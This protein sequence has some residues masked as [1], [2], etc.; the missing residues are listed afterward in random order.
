VCFVLA[1]LF[2]CVH[3]VS[4]EVVVSTEVDMANGL[5]K[6]DLDSLLVCMAL[7]AYV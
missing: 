6:N 7:Y 1:C 5:L 4:S 3:I 2:V